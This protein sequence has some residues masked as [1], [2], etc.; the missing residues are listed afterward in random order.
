MRATSPA[1]CAKILRVDLPR[2]NDIFLAYSAQDR[3]LAQGYAEAFRRE[4]FSV[5]WDLEDIPIGRV[6]EDEIFRV[7]ADCACVV[8]LW[9]PASVGSEWVQREAEFALR[10]SK[11][12]PVIAAPV[13]IPTA[14][15]RIQT[16]ELSFWDVRISEHAVFQRLLKS[17]RYLVDTTPRE[18][19]QTRVFKES[20]DIAK[21]RAEELRL[22]N[23]SRVSCVEHL[24]LMKTA[25]FE[26]LSWNL[27]PGVNVLLGRNGFGKTYLLRALVALLQYDDAACREALGSGSGEALLLLDGK[28]AVIRFE[29]KYFDEAEAVGQL[30]VLAI[31]DTRF[32]NRSQTTI[33]AVQDNA[34][35]GKGDRAEP[36]IFGA[37]HFLNDQPYEDMIQ[38]LFYGLCLD[39]VEAGGRFD[40]EQ[41]T[42]IEGVVR[43]LTDQ[44]F[45]FKRVAREGRNRFTL[46]VQTEGSD[47]QELPIQ[48]ASQGTSS[49]I[50]LI[51]LIYE[52]LKSLRQ[53]SDVPV[54]GRTGIV[55]IDEIDAHLHPL[56]QQKLVGLLRSRF[57]KVQFIL[58]A[59]NPILVAGCLEEEVSVLRKSEGR[60]FSLVQFPNDFVGW[61]SERLY[62]TVFDVEK[63]DASFTHFKA[64]R[65]FRGQFKAEA[66]ALRAKTLRSAEDDQQLAQLE[67]QLL[68]IDKAEQA[69]AERLSQEELVRDNRN[70]REQLQV[71]ASA[72]EKD[73]RVQR[74]AAALREAAERAQ[75]EAAAVREQANSDVQAAQLELRR[76]GMDFDALRRRLARTRIVAT[77]LAAALGAALFWRFA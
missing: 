66:D 55:I 44:S 18:A 4:G 48:K 56:W 72:G 39:C 76:V 24:S 8:V 36:A 23:I 19:E 46:Y 15:V 2:R 51:G 73:E 70:L 47:G 50:A 1:R 42:L 20:Q 67:E 75:Q 59:H 60:G 12:V 32:V 16:A 74:E 33:G 53:A 69:G 40:G 43:E 9:T 54:C 61:T 65:P 63:P 7:L 31:P 49:V 22:R 29:Q 45:A 26:A 28:E 35:V 17:I 5:W 14:F 3:L 21:R 71:L 52:Y 25:F 38:A 77:L 62:R 6:F 34:R 58:T 57:P 64:L 68:Y 11:L 27:Q 13:E 10:Q 41:F 37:W 30:P